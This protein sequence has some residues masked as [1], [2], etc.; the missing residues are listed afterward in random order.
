MA[1]S[2]STLSLITRSWDHAAGAP[3]VRIDPLPVGSV[4][5]Y[6]SDIGAPPQPCPGCGY[7]VAAKACERGKD[8]TAMVP[9]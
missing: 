8:C 6:A 1:R 2:D 3:T 4:R 7:T 9:K 5:I